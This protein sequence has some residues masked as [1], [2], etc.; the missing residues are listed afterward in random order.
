MNDVSSAA[1]VKNSAKWSNLKETIRNDW[2]SHPPK[3][4]FGDVVRRGAAYRW[5]VGVSGEAACSTELEWLSRVACGVSTKSKRFHS[6]DPIEWIAKFQESLP[7]QS[8]SMSDAVKTLLYTAAMPGLLDRVSEDRWWGLLGTIQ[9]FRESLMRQEREWLIKTLGVA[10]IGL[11]LAW[12]LRALPSC[13]RSLESSLQTLHDWMDPMDAAV[14]ITLESP[15]HTRLVLGSAWRMRCLINAI[16]KSGLWGKKFR[17]GSSQIKRILQSLDELI[18]ELSTWCAAMTRS[19]GTATLS[20]LD[21]SAVRDDSDSRGVLR[22]TAALDEECLL[23]AMN[24]A[25]GDN[26]SRGRLAWQISLPESMLH[27][28][29]AKLACLLPEWDVRRGRAMMRYADEQVQLE[30]A[31]GKSPLISGALQ[32][33]ILVDGTWCQPTGEWIATCEYTDDDVHYLEIEQPHDSGFVLQRQLMVVREDRCCMFADAVV[34]GLAEGQ[35]GAGQGESRPAIEYRLRLPLAN[36]CG[37][38]PAEETTEWFLETSKQQAIVFPLAASEWRMAM[39][40]GQLSLT[41]DN[42]LLW[43]VRGAGGLFAPLWIDFDRKRMRK[44]RTWRSLTV[45]DQLRVVGNWEAASYRI[46]VA[47]SQW[48][49]YRSLVSHPL[50]RTF[51]GKHIIA[52][53]YGARFDAEEQSYEDLITVENN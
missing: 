7:T 2:D 23:P 51:F 17:R 47:K 33:D 13:Q 12:S 34:P 5:G 32:T 49:L 18:V 44:A 46:Q 16:A 6:L 3:L 52:D 19:D 14:T 40:P 31:A 15:E 36:G 8:E 28:E 10:E 20:N 41:G 53:F 11:T 48:I 35:G 26:Q 29:D 38:S 37:A 9:S 21:R 24:A 1:Q 30:L 50:P 45:G 22:T 25:L 39:S 43:S 42:H 4:V 27:D